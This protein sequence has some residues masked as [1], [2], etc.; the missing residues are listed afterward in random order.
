M[1]TVGTVSGGSVRGDHTDHLGGPAASGDDSPGGQIRWYSYESIP[2]LINYDFSNEGVPTDLN[3][4][5][6]VTLPGFV[7]NPLQAIRK[8]GTRL[9]EI[10]WHDDGIE[11]EVPSDPG[12]VIIWRDDIPSVPISFLDNLTQDLIQKFADMIWKWTSFDGWSPSVPYPV[13]L[14]QAIPLQ[15]SQF[16]ADVN[17]LLAKLIKLPGFSVKFG[18]IMDQDIAITKWDLNNVSYLGTNPVFTDFPELDLSNVLNNAMT[19]LVN[20]YFHPDPIQKGTANSY[21]KTFKIQLYANIT[22]P[23]T[24]PVTIKLGPQVTFK[25]LPIGIPILAVFFADADFQGA[26]LFFLPSNTP[27]IGGGHWDDNIPRAG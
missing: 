23:G 20:V 14:G 15:I 16:A 9:P 22:L 4:T 13:G 17:N 6:V 2:N 25:P 19:N 11:F 5:N 24:K 8:S 26:P 21:N 27:V 18:F 7:T 12:V 10:A 1:I 3:K